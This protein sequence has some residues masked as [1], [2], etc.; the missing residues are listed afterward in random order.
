MARAPFQQ[1]LVNF[2][3]VQIA[4]RFV[5]IQHVRK[6]SPNYNVGFLLPE[7]PQL[8]CLGCPVS[9]ISLPV[10]VHIM[11]PE[12]FTER[13]IRVIQNITPAHAQ[14][15]FQITLFDVLQATHH[16]SVADFAAQP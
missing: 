2:L 3:S 7:R 1:P 14:D 5:R 12:E 11:L 10:N 13:G 6:H 8:L 15:L 9:T 16:A 4:I